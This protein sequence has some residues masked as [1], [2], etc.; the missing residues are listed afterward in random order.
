MMKKK[1]RMKR[2]RKKD[3]YR[4]ATAT[5]KSLILLKADKRNPD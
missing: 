5:K 2:S 3:D 4:F 1:I